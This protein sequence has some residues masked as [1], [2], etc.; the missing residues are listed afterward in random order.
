MCV[1][2]TLIWNLYDKEFS[3][4]VLFWDYS[5]QICIPKAYS[6]FWKKISGG[7]KRMVDRLFLS[8]IKWLLMHMC[9]YCGE[10]GEHTTKNKKFMKFY[11]V[12]WLVM[13]F[14]KTWYGTGGMLPCNILYLCL[15]VQGTC[16]SINAVLNVTFSKHLN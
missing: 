6:D 13:V 14:K 12:V 10:K 15:A 3:R 8:E 7:A 1:K 4:E 2:N 9:W 16:H 5:K 11:F